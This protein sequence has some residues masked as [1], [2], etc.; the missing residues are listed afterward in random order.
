MTDVTSNPANQVTE[1]G[2][3]VWRDVWRRFRTHR[4]AF[5]SLFVLGFILVAILV[6][7]EVLPYG[8]RE[9]DD[10]A[11][12]QAPS[13]AHLLG[14]DELGRDQLARILAGG[15]LTYATAG[16]AVLAAIVVG[17]AVGITAGYLGGWVDAVLMRLTD[18]FYAMPGLFVVILLVALVGPG[19]LT[20]VVSI[21]L[22]SW[23][24]TARLVRASGLGLKQKEFVEAAYASGVPGVRIALRHVIPNALTPVIVTAT[25]G[26]ALAILVESALSFLGLGFQPPQATWGGML[27]QSQRA[28]MLEGHWWRGLFPGLMIFGSVLCANFVGDG[29]RDSLDPRQAKR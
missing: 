20:I 15:R 19:Y 29:L 7:P 28:V 27:E 25:L 22:F 14:T 12:D 1:T 23:M 13:L 21:S 5:V 10:A 2:S 8:P 24:N 26:L 18:V 3:S 11:Q 16:A 6:G 4:P 17:V 9:T